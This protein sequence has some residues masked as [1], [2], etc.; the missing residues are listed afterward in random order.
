MAKVLVV[1]DSEN[2]RFFIRRAIERFP[3]F[4]IVGELTDGEEAVEYLSGRGL[5]ADR[6]K[7]PIPDLMVLDLKMPRRTGF[8]SFARLW[9]PSLLG[10]LN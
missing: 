4:Q 3:R 9:P 1:D 5:F 2:D 10:W 6:R 7:H 8:R